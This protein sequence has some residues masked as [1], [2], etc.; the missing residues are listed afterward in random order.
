MMRWLPWY[1]LASAAWAALNLIQAWRDSES[2]HRWTVRE[3]L[4]APWWMQPP[5]FL[6]MLASGAAWPIMAPLTL[7]AYLAWAARDRWPSAKR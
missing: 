1:L 5:F 6:V 4:E 7:A 2:P 3:A